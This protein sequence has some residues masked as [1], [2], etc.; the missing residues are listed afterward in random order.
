MLLIG[1]LL[2]WACDEAPP[3]VQPVKYSHKIHIDNGMPCQACHESVEKAAAASVPTKDTCMLCHQATITNSPEEEKVRQYAENGEEIPWRRVYQLPD[4]VFFSHRRHVAVARIEC[5][6]C[7]G[8]VAS[9]TVPP[10]SPLVNQSM[11][12]CLACHKA[13]GV[14]EDCVH[15]HR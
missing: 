1:G 4:H 8:A 13:R 11:D 9:L 14:S 6:E 5:G 3:V 7:H 15:C 10:S 2:F 12:W